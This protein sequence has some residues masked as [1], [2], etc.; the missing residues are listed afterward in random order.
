MATIIITVGPPLAGKSTWAKGFVKRNPEYVRVNRDDLRYMLKDS[1]R[2]GSDREALITR[3]SESIVKESL[4]SGNKVILDNTHC[5]NKYIEEICAKF[6]NEQYIVVYFIEPMWKLKLR[7]ILRWIKTGKWIPPHVIDQMD[8]N[9]RRMDLH[10]LSE[11][12]NIIEV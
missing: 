9:M 3:I 2:V 4:E 11:K 1:L 8:I 7:N 5:K 12:Y 6:P 10:Q